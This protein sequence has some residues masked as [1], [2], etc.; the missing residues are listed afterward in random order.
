M[1]TKKKKNVIK[2][3][4]AKRKKSVMFQSRPQHIIDRNHNR[5]VFI[6]TNIIS[7]CI[8]HRILLASSC[9]CK[10]FIVITVFAIK[11]FNMALKTVCHPD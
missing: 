5:Q 8:N 7:L 1:S 6:F 2:S 10:R 4:L 11:L 3:V 9:K